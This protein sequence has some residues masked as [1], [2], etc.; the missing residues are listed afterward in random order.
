M[1]LEA[2]IVLKELHE[3]MVRR[4]CCKYYYKEN[5]GC[6]LLVANFIQKYS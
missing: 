5:Y 1:T 3:G 4:H 2:Q 6:R